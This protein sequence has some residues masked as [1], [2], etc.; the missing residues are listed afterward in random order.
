M[1]KMTSKPAHFSVRV[2]NAWRDAAGSETCQSQGGKM[3]DPGNEVGT[4]HAS[5]IVVP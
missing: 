2:N 5:E 3:R 1:D 4:C